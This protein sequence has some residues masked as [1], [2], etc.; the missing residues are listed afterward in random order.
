MDSNIRHENIRL[1]VDNNISRVF[2]MYDRNKTHCI[3]LKSTITSLHSNMITNID[4]CINIRSKIVKSLP[5]I[6]KIEHSHPNLQEEV[7][8]ND[9]IKCRRKT[10]KETHWEHSQCIPWLKEFANFKLCS[11]YFFSNFPLCRTQL[12]FVFFLALLEYIT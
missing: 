1:N 10:K 2:R 3:I 7:I 8:P 6:N 4:I 9:N 11:T 12:L 5:C